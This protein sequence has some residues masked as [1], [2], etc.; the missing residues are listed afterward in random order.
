MGGGGAKGEGGGSR[1]S[2]SF[3]LATYALATASDN[4]DD[5]IQSSGAV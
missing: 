1:S 4:P 3:T 5:Y 2:S